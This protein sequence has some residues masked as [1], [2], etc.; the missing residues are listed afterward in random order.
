METVLILKEKDFESKKE[1]LSYIAEELSFPNY[2]GNNL[3]ALV[4]CLREVSEPTNIALVSASTD[5]PATWYR[6]ICETIIDCAIENEKISLFV[7]IVIEK[8]EED[9]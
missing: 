6:D 7:P 1:M 9:W 3:D 5:E 4:D 8:D 2:F